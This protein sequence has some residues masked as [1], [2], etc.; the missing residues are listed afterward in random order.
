MSWTVV[1]AAAVYRVATVRCE[2]R[3]TGL[4]NTGRARLLEDD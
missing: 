3:A 2:I 1:S 4:A